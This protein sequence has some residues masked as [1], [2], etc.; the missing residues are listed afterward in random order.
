MKYLHRTT[1]LCS[2]HFRRWQ[3]K[4]GKSRRKINIERTKPTA[5]NTSRIRNKS[6]RARTLSNNRSHLSC[7]KVHARSIPVWSVCS[8]QHSPS[9]RRTN[10][11]TNDPPING[12]L[13]FY[14]P[15][16]RFLL[17]Q[18]IQESCR[19]HRLLP[20][21]LPCRP[22]RRESTHRPRRLWSISNRQRAPFSSTRTVNRIRLWM[23]RRNVS[24]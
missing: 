3:R 11:R 24:V 20:L 8:L 15:A 9:F 7:H 5:T 18:P 14:H 22:R 12:S 23:E 2:S 21:L 6:K 13:S 17:F 4:I 19:Q 16:V 10:E 1:D